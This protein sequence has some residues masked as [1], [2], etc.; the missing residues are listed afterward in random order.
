M[1]EGQSVIALSMQSPLGSLLAGRDVGEQVVI[2]GRTLIVEE[3][4]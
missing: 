1:V 3:I 2:N 4:L